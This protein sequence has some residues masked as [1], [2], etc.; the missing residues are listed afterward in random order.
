MVELL[1]AMVVG[2]I[3]MTAIYAMVNL[4][5]GT[6][7]G[8]GR[9]IATQQDSRAVLDLMAMEVSMVSFNPSL[10]NATWTGNMLGSCSERTT[11]GS[12]S[13]FDSILG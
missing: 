1:I 6:S 8:V 3:I 5:Q 11:A 7:A 10:T 9:R 12:N 2:I 13:I 4:S